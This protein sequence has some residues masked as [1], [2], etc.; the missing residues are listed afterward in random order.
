MKATL[1][2]L[3]NIDIFDGING[4]KI[5]IADAQNDVITLC[6]DLT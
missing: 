4:H 6:R 2:T 1:I 5:F 3:N